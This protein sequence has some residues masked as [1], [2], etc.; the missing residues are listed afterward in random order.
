MAKAE[1]ISPASRGF[2]H[3]SFCSWRADTFQHFHVAGVGRGTVQRF[4][5]EG[6]FAQL[7]RDIGVIEVRQ[8]FAGFR[9]G[10]KEVPQPASARLLLGTFQQFQLARVV[11]PAVLLRCSR[12]W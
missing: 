3:F 8:T 5:G 11:G 10:Q 6:V 2:S 9:V 7:S 12:R 4:G 1:R